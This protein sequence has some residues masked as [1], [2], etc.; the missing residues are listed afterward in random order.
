MSIPLTA[1]TEAF[2]PPSMAEVEGAPSFTFRHATVLDKHHF[3]R[4]AVAEGLMQHNDEEVREAIISEL[5]LRFDSEGLEQNI[6]G[7]QSMWQAIDEL[8][9]ARRI[10]REQ[11]LEILQAAEEG[12]TPELPPEPELEFDL[13]RQQALE[14]LIAEVRRHSDRVNMMLADNMWYGNMFPRILLRMFLKTTTLPVELKRRHN[15]LTAEAC[16]ELI[17]KLADVAREAGVDDDRAVSELLVEATLAFALRKD[18]EKN[19]SSPRSGITNRKSSA[20]KPSSS[21]TET[22]STKSPDPAT[23]DEANGSISSE[24]ECPANP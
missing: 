23:G 21:Q 18:E 6:T 7:L 4:I 1:S 20:S 9:A 16:E 24:S 5:R 8:Q 17:E 22:S 13:E 10:H 2:T 15:I 12:D 3:H 14:D 19:S 11:C